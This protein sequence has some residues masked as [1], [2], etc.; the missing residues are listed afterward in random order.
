MIYSDKGKHLF[1]DIPDTAIRKKKSQYE[2]VVACNSSII[3]ST[4]A[5]CKM[6]YSLNE[7]NLVERMIPRKSIK[8][9]V[10]NHIPEWLK[11]RIIKK[12]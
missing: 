8:N 6:K 7:G 11:Y 12:L 9:V 4:D 2:T 10:K 5:N 3:K 1:K